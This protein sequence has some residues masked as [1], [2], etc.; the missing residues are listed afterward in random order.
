MNMIIL[1]KHLME[2]N[3]CNAGLVVE[4]AIK[5]FCLD[6]HKLQK[7][8]K[9]NAANSMQTHLVPKDQ[10]GKTKEDYNEGEK[11]RCDWSVHMPQHE[12]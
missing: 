8:K 9:K 2:E 1:L 6:M 3:W 7:K 12:I 4:A 11:K 5:Q 10:V